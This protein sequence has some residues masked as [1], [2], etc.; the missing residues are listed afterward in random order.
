MSA[1]HTGPAANFVGRQPELA[2]VDRCVAEVRQG[3]PAVLLVRGPAGI[4]KSSLVRSALSRHPDIT[5]LQTACDP[6][7]SDF[8]YGMIQQL[9]AGLPRDVVDPFSPLGNNA[10]PPSTAP[11]LVGVQLIGL[12]GHLQQ[13]GPVA[14][15]IDDVQWADTASLHALGFVLRRLWADQVLV[16]LTARTD[17]SAG[18]AEDWERL[19][20]GRENAEIIDLHGLTAG[21]VAELSTIAGL[22][23]AAAQRLHQHTEG[24]P[25]HL[26]TLL[27]D[28]S[29]DE[30]ARPEALL[31]VPSTLA[32]AVGHQTSQLD[33]APLKL[34]HALAVLNG[35]YPLA[36][37][38]ALAEVED[39]SV[40]L[41]PLLAA[42]LVKWSPS[43][44]AS[45]VRM[46]HALQREAVYQGI[47]PSQRSALHSQAATLVDRT[48]AWRHRVAAADAT[49]PALADDLEAE[50][51][52]RLAEGNIDAAVTYLL[53]AGP[54][55]PA[56]EE[57]ER[58]LL[59][60]GLHLAWTGK[61]NRLSSLMPR[62]AACRPSTLRSV[63]ME[64][65]S[66]RAGDH[67]RE[68]A[69]RQAVREASAGE[70]AV[71]AAAAGGYF[72]A[73]YYYSTDRI[74][75]DINNTRQTLETMG[76]RLPDFF[77]QQTLS[78][79]MYNQSITDGPRSA[80]AE[81][82]R[83][84]P[85]APRA[86]D[87]EPAHIPM[88][89]T[90]G[91]IRG[92]AGDLRASITDLTTAMNRAHQHAI[93]LT[94]GG[95]YSSLAVNQ[96][97]L[98][99]WDEALVNAD[100]SLAV[101]EAQD[102]QWFLPVAHMVSVLLRAGR[103]DWENA[104]LHLKKLGTRGRGLSHEIHMAVAQASL[105]HAA[106]DSQAVLAATSFL[107][108]RAQKPSWA[109][110]ERLLWLPW[111]TDALIAAGQYEQASAA[112][113]QLQSFAQENASLATAVAWLNGS[114]AWAR[115]NNDQAVQ[116]FEF[117]ST[118]RNPDEILPH[119]A[120]LAHTFGRYLMDHADRRQAVS[121]LRTA[122]QIYSSLG[123]APFVERCAEDLEKCGLRASQEA[124]RSF[125][126]LNERE[127]VI[128]HLVS[129]G[130]TN[131][132]AA[133]HLFISTKTI[134]YHLSRIYTKLG[135]ASRRDLR[136]RLVE[137]GREQS[138]DGDDH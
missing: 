21:E 67:S 15:T 1:A 112:I 103:G 53:W 134:E 138:Q 63:L 127:S 122:H 24:H 20:T 60:A 46:G 19:A 2:T 82:E 55:S 108:E 35:T 135:I 56:L 126:T 29:T 17:S 27:Q 10:I 12:L 77:R 104:R 47:A 31:P 85:L 93:P 49:D 73:T 71:W 8:S 78:G 115:E 74:Q 75:D 96:Y 52:H 9:A 41:E 48:A 132:E 44:P 109:R 119:R 40:A 34:L 137:H 30:L 97:L 66:L 3:H 95:I 54:L 128:A 117:G 105:A 81:I 32:D 26:Q 6:S 42:G 121:H 83:T 120:Q 76:D 33:P 4:G 89:M 113:D 72:L 136:S 11:Y 86:R 57:Q 64:G 106:G 107:A 102:L 45:P 62:I 23:S 92:Q 84:S 39:P 18:N 25:L 68:G 131:Q 123:A 36:L 37:V 133:N 90:R 124:P 129:Q 14:L 91:I 101:S 13:D 130:M 5:V 58:R 88:L 16:V 114:L 98:G 43:E 118:L 59:A 99:N 61:Q 111:H 87:V 22:D 80:L 65:W 79:L 110:S 70:D 125:L 50:A 100:H 94:D 69:L 51:V 7:E 28:I 116:Q 38:A